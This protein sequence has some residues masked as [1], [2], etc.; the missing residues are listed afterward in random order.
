MKFIPIC[1]VFAGV[2][3]PLLRA[4]SKPTLSPADYGKWE[5]LGAG[6]LSPDGK[7]LA[8][9]IRRSDRSDELRVTPTSGGKTHVI[10][11]CSGAAFSADSQW[12]A[13]ETTVSEAEQ[14]RLRK[15]RRPIQNK[16]SVLELA[17]GSVTT[18]DEVQSFAFSGNQAYVAFRRY[19][20]ARE[21]AAAPAANA[22]AGRG[23]RGGGQNSDGESDPVGSAL[24]VRNLAT[25]IDTT[26]GNVTAFAWQDGGTNLAVAIGIEGRAGN[27]LQVFDPRAGSLKVLDSGPALFADLVW[28]KESSD[29]AALRSVKK[30]G[31]EGES[32][33]VLAWKG[34]GE[35]R[36]AQV[37]APKRIVAARAPQWSED[38]NTV[39]VGVAEWLKK[40]ET[41]RS[42]DDPSTV[43]VWHWK[44]VNVVSEQRL[45][46]AR[47]RDRN[48]LA[49]WHI[50]SGKLVTLAANPKEDVRLSKRGTRALA[51]DGVPYEVDGEFG[52]RYSNVYQVNLETG[53]RAPVATHV[54]PP[55]DFSPGGRYALQY[56]GTDFWVFDLEAN[57][58]RDISKE[59]PTSFTNKE[60]DHPVEQKP[61]YGI[62][63][64]T[65]D[66]HSVIVYDAYDLW[67]L[68]P[69]GKTKP[70]R[71]TNGASEEIRHRYVRMEPRAAGGGRGGRGGRGGG[72]DPEW[73]DLSKP[74]YLSLEG[75]WTKKTGYA[76]LANGN[77]ER[78]VW[79]DKGIRG[80]EKAKDADVLLYQAGS[81]DDS[82]NFFVAGMDLKNPR[83]VSDTNPFAAQY[84]WG[85]AEL[86]DYKNS[87]GERLQGA[88]YYPANYERGKKYPMIVQIYEIE[89]NQLH[90]WTAPSERATYNALVWTERGY[91][92]YRPDIT[93][94]PREPGISAL[95]CVTSGVKKVLETGMVDAKKV[96]LVGH[97]W[98]GY[99]T[100][101]IATQTDMFAA[102]VA[103]G[104]LTNLASSYG[105]IYWNSGGPET[106][107]AE[108]GQERM[109][110]PLY[111]DPQA[112]IRNS[113][114]YFA[115]K[116]HPPLLLS[117]G[118]HDGASDWHQ[119]IELYNSARRAGKTV[120]MLVY[121][122]ENHSVAQK[123]NQI[124][125]HR[126]IN[127]WFDHY[128]K[129]NDPKDWITKGVTVLDRE[130]EL[131][132]NGQTGGRGAVNA[133]PVG[134]VTG[135][136][137]N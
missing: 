48:A 13:C 113:A 116:L 94:R 67:E 106:D 44:D 63:G 129:G 7:W 46:A 35:K 70:R 86:V 57:S 97:S 110:V 107:H 36:S 81:W 18:V 127:D 101:F 39:Y 121:E 124:D 14:D 99:E 62:A 26:F 42:E 23:G 59:A 4:Q 53:D 85:R 37:E 72:E 12:L 125:Y 34:L 5:T 31:Y 33:A 128:L 82:P 2:V 9:E 24:T 100:T 20:P 93:F 19:P 22:P 89:S 134:S 54:V 111:E 117:V 108:T 77:V 69:D 112:Y 16:L 1:L 21:N 80:L 50:A 40:L 105:E 109:E 126:R 79:L 74:V 104:P 52:R 10:A 55:V 133:S 137:Q 131:K 92:V 29:L 96:G 73:I 58:S 114:V 76:R 56:K 45:N 65:K 95:D 102:A 32:Y 115:N 71:L 30:E 61:S 87:K 38:G 98:G 123:A 43:E 11:F 27:A 49:A 17:T 84:A 135:G 136:G 25:G 103:G 47:D 6:T 130:R 90:N 75:R 15:A 78:L 41:H 122:G 3:C 64:W 28:R 60:N 132:S 119:D 91:F 120:V 118:D 66:D 83:K 8:H 68:F 88:L 51:L